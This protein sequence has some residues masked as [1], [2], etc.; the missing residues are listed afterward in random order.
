[1]LIGPDALKEQLLTRSVLDQTAKK[2]HNMT[3]SI[4]HSKR[5]DNIFSQKDR[6]SQQLQP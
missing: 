3:L 1:M 5:M 4:N 2:I 6:A